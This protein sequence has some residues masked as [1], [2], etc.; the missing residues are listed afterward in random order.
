MSKKK[1]T[2]SAKRAENPKHAPALTRHVA[3]G[4][5]RPPVVVLLEPM[6]YREQRRIIQRAM[7]LGWRVIDLVYYDRRLPAGLSP[8]GALVRRLW[9]EPVVRSLRKVGCPIVRC[10]SFPN[11][12]DDVLPAVVRD[13]PAAG[14]LAAEHFVDRN[15]HHVGFVGGGTPLS[16]FEP[17]YEAFRARAVELG[18]ECHLFAYSPLAAEASAL[19]ADER[20]HLRDHEIVEWVKALPKPVGI[21]GFSSEMGARICVRC[22]D[23]GLKVPGEVAVLSLGDDPVT[24]Q[25]T[26][27][28]LS[29]I[30]LGEEQVGEVAVELLR[31]LM[32]GKPAPTETVLVA[33]REVTVRESTDVLATKD[34]V[35]ADAVRFMWKHIER[36]LSVEDVAREVGVGRSTLDR[37][38]AN[39][40]GR[41]VISELQRR[42]LTE[43]CHLLRSTD[44]PI[45]DLAPLVGFRTMAHLHRLFRKTYGM[46][47]RQYRLQDKDRQ[48]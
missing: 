43:L 48:A 5:K 40:L 38:F 26:P 44:D 21:V 41:S 19:S 9:H 30:D 3:P 34:P 1:Q 25:C 2:A 16:T 32:A 23:A 13:L 31:D 27:L 28:P 7:E 45:A 14:R 36:D 10:G 22:L 17:T 24:C 42:R 29:A 18:C 11:P 46:S 39:S 37:L 12:H 6:F 33:P 20:R 15:F 8:D 35:V 4:A 47:P